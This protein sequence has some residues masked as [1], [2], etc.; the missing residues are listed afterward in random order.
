[1]TKLGFGMMRLPLKDPDDKTSIDFDLLDRMVDRYLGS[2]N[3]YFDTAYM[4]HGG[5]SESALRRSLVERYPR[6]SFR[7]ATKMPLMSLKKEGD[8]ERIFEEQLANCGVD[9][10]DSYLLHNVCGEFIDTVERF[11]TFDFLRSK[12]KEGRI[13][14]LGFSFHDQADLLDRVLTENPD[15]DFVQLQVNYID[16]DDPSIQSREC[17]EVARRHGVPIVVMEPVKGGL[18]A[19]VPEDVRRMYSEVEPSFSPATWAIRFAASVDGVETVLSG[20]SDMAQLEENI[21]CLEGF[22]GFDDVHMD[23]MERAKA[24]IRSSVAVPCTA[25]RYC[26]KSCPNDILIADYISLYN[27]EKANP[28]EGFSLQALYYGNISRN[29]GRASDCVGCGECERNC[30]QHLRISE[31]M[32]DVA[33]LFENRGRKD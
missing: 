23:A 16:W 32:G 12:K 20:M 13:R 30:P 29:H 21:A 14:R 7:I 1:M 19:D 8:Q 17:C 2:G 22:T 26:M 10:F 6:D 5:T 15:M 28:K 9:Y 4:Y 24:S 31:I 33:G 27:A 11:G 3:D 18:L 25:C